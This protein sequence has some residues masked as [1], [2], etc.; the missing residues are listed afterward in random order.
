MRQEA[1]DGVL[2]VSH[3]AVNADPQHRPTHGHRQE[4][5][6]NVKEALCDSVQFDNGLADR[7]DAD[8]HGEG[9]QPI[10]HP[11]KP[12]SDEGLVFF[13]L[14]LVRYHLTGKPK[15]DGHVHQQAQHESC[16]LVLC[17]AHHLK[18]KR[19][20]PL[21]HEHEILRVTC[22]H[23]LQSAASP[24]GQGQDDCLQHRRGAEHAE[25]F[26]HRGAVEHDPSEDP[27]GGESEEVSAKTLDGVQPNSTP[28]ELEAKDVQSG[29]EQDVAK[30]S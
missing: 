26:R 13:G 9:E 10:C 4:V 20:A 29:Q 8:R 7:R 17:F 24:H 22:D 19:V 27:N 16:C 23:R 21:G 25:A 28:P 11:L 18:P 1:H 5:V 14:R 6:K 2:E 12:G 30:G 3:R 15:A